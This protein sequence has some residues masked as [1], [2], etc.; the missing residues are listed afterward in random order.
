M[1]N[2]NAIDKNSDKLSETQ[3][4]WQ[5]WK[6]IEWN[7]ENIMDIL[8][9]PEEKA[10]LMEMMRNPWLSWQKQYAIKTKDGEEIIFWFKIIPLKDWWTVIIP[11]NLTDVSLQ[12][13]AEDL[14]TADY[15]K[16]F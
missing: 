15:I 4:K 9:F 5:L 2:L 11:D 14:K 13:L 7:K 8:Y 1:T 3:D 16:E 10:K 6:V 12:Q